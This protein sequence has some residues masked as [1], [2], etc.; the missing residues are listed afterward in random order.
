[1][2]GGEIRAISEVLVDSL[3]K[4]FSGVEGRVAAARTFAQRV[5]AAAFPDRTPDPLHVPHP[6]FNQW[7][8]VANQNLPAAIDVSQRFRVPTV[9]NSTI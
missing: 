3:N 7:N 8:R 2:R 6:S 1:M 5:V 4:R 9:D